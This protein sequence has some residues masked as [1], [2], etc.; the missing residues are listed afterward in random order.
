[1]SLVQKRAESLEEVEV[2]AGG[3]AV[4]DHVVHLLHLTVI[5]AGLTVGHL[6]HLTALRVGLTD[7]PVTIPKLM[8]ILGMELV[9]ALLYL[10]G[11]A[12]PIVISTLTV[13]IL[14]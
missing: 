7:L 8:V 5:R 2:V 1:M 3:E 14:I 9:V 6:L 12:M 13:P 4:L 11:M 10:V